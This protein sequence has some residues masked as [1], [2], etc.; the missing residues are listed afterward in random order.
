LSKEKQPGVDPRGAAVDALSKRMADQMASILEAQAPQPPAIKTITNMKWLAS[1]ENGDGGIAGTGDGDGD[2]AGNADE[3]TVEIL[4]EEGSIIYGQLLIEA[5]TDAPGP[6][7]AQIVTGPYAGSRM[8]GSFEATDNYLIL[9]FNSIVI[10]GMGHET[11]AVAIDPDTTLPGVV[12]EIDRRYFKR[13]IL[14]MAAEFVRGLSEAVSE[15]GST[16]ITID[17]GGTTTSQT[18]EDKDEE[19]E[20]ASGIEAA[21]EKFGELIEEEAQNTKPM[22]RVAAGTPLGILFVEPVTEELAE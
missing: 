14:P 2:G 19:Q 21:G 15:S 13:I 11:Q 22:I 4:I 17:S 5:N 10:D 7:L 9:S 3:A 18:N 20:V 1:I 12:T 6:V 8:L 16:T